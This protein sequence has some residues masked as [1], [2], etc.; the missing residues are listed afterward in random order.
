MTTRAYGDRLRTA[1]KRAGPGRLPYADRPDVGAGFAGASAAIA[2]TLAFAFGVVA[3]DELGLVGGLDGTVL[4][5]TGLAALP[6]VAPAAFAAGVLTWRAL[7]DGLPIYGVA[8]GFLG[9]VFTYLG[10]TAL[11]AL[12]LVLA[13][14]GSWS[15]VML[16]DAFLF[17]VG[18]GYIGF[19]LTAWVTV[20]IGCLSGAIYE[21]VGLAG[22]SE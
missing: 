2:A 8:A 11:L 21:R 17:A 6:L 19:L 5:T 18:I 15:E 10:A 3:V 20:P 22:Q 16:T 1:C 13:A 7:P 12:V 9:T 4:A 14:W